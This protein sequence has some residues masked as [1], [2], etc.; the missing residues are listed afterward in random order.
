MK[1]F[2]LVVLIFFLSMNSLVSPVFA[3]V[4]SSNVTVDLVEV[5]QNYSKYEVYDHINNSIEYIEIKEIG[6]EKTI[7]SYAGD[8]IFKIV[9][10]ENNIQYYE[11][12]KLI[13]S[14]DKKNISYINN[15]NLEGDYMLYSWGPWGGCVW[16]TSS[17]SVRASTVSA[18]ISIIA[19]IFGVPP[20]AS[21]AITIGTT[22][23][24]N[25]INDVYY[26][27]CRK[28]RT[29]RSEGI[30]EMMETIYMYSRSDYTGYLGSNTTSW[31]GRADY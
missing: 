13:D 14:I 4:E 2:L 20:H 22:V 11:N 26:K 28:S 29:N 24:D 15:D 30:Y 23:H 18:C 17:R 12:D 7:T 19:S 8:Y 9:E 31:E 16:S 27:I 25:H 10:D 21:I 6:G 5:G 1:K 3:V